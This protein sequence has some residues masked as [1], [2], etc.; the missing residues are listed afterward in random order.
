M[1]KRGNKGLPEL[2]MNNFCFLWHTKTD[3]S[4]HKSYPMYFII[5]GRRRY[6]RKKVLPSELAVAVPPV[7]R[8]FELHQYYLHFFFIPTLPGYYEWVARTDD[9]KLIA[10]TDSSLEDELIEKHEKGVPWR[11]YIGFILFLTVPLALFLSMKVRDYIEERD[12]RAFRK[13]ENEVEIG[14]IMHP[15]LNDYFEFNVSGQGLLWTKVTNI[16]ETAIQLQPA[17]EINSKN[18]SCH[19]LDTLF[20][21]DSI[22]KRQPEWIS[23]RILKEMAGTEAGRGYDTTL[24][25]IGSMSF[26]QICKGTTKQN[27]SD[28]Q[29]RTP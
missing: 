26:Y 29:D 27:V 3:L 19:D 11:A 6:I 5:F 16:S 18:Y 8:Q 17:S 25:N 28:R 7:I 21:N 20:A 24:F 13:H 4:Q 12:Y 23:K 1:K 22:H 2:Y 10:I 15:T 9:N 14:N